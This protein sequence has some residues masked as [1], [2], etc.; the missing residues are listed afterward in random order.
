M[1]HPII[2]RAEAKELGLG[3]FYTGVPCRRDHASERYTKTGLCV[4]CAALRNRGI[5]LEPVGDEDGGAEARA[6]RKLFTKKE[7]EAALDRMKYVNYRTC[8]IVTPRLN[9]MKARRTVQ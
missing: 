5:D 1:T 6:I 3:R 9:S 2:S 4:A 8:M 7:R